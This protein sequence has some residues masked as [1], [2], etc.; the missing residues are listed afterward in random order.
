MCRLCIVLKA[1]AG[2]FRMI[3]WDLCWCSR[4]AVTQSWEGKWWTTG[5]CEILSCYLGSGLSYLKHF[6]LFSENNLN[7]SCSENQLCL[8][9]TAEIFSA[10]YWSYL[11]ISSIFPEHPK[12]LFYFFLL[13]FFPLFRKT[14]KES[15]AESASNITESLMGISR[16]MSQQVQQSEETVQ[17]LGT[18]GIWAWRGWWKHLWSAL[19]AWG[20]KQS[21]R[22]CYSGD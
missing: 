20:E 9:Y 7:F 14:T 16:M 2:I 12:K 13:F 6:L 18:A 22:M 8:L 19:S 4:N 17:T 5:P 11:P 1:T 3:K 15:L 10:K 21:R